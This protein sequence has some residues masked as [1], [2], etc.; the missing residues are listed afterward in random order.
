MNHALSIER[1]LLT[2]WVGGMWTVG[3][4]VAPTLFAMLD[5]RPTAG[6]IAGQLFS[7]INYVGLICGLLLLALS[8]KFRGRQSIRQWR[9]WIVA[10]MLVLIAIGQFVVTPLMQEIKQ[11][12]LAAKLMSPDMHE[13]FQLL[14]G[15]STTLFVMVSILGLVLAWFGVLRPVIQSGR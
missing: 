14:H 11:A 15:I 8:F 3:F 13:Q 12:R 4:L 5:S 9:T 2:I 7:T 1:I 6:N 10:S